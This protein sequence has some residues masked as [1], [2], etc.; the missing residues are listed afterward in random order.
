MSRR[1]WLS[2]QEASCFYHE[3]PKLNREGVYSHYGL[4]HGSHSDGLYPGAQS[5]RRVWPESGPDDATM[6]RV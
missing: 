5:N 2:E 1:Q 3:V 4:R 6:A